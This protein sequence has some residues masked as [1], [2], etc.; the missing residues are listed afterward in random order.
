MTPRPS[1]DSVRRLL[2]QERDDAW[3]VRMLPRLVLGLAAAY[4]LFVL[5]STGMASFIAVCALIVLAGILWLL[6]R[7]GQLLL[8]LGS[9]AVTA[10]MT[11]YLAAAGDIARGSA[12]GLLSGQA[13]FGYWALSGMALLGAWM[14]KRPRGRRGVTVVLADGLLIAAAGVGMF[15]PLFGVPLGFLCTVGTL[16]LRSRRAGGVSGSERGTKRRNLRRVM[17]VADTDAR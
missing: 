7:R 1:L 14:L 13:V 2:R 4:T 6:R 8:A 17:A 12:G 16:A 3:A 9:T 11:G 5:A 15:A 10:A